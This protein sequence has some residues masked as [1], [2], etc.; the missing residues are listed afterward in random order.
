MFYSDAPLCQLHFAA[1]LE[2][3]GHFGDVARR[4]W[5]GAGAEWHEFGKR[6]IAETEGRSIHLND[7]EEHEAKE[8]EFAKQVENMAPPGTRAKIAAEKLAQL[9]AAEQKAWNTPAEKRTPKQ[10][11]LAALVAPRL[12]VACDEIALRVAG[13]K[14][15]EARQLAAKAAHHRQMAAEVNGYRSLVNFDY[16]RL[17]AQAEQTKEAIEARKT[18]WDGDQADAAADLVKARDFYEKGL[19]GWRKVL[20]RFPKLKED[21]AV[22]VDEL[23]EMIQRYRRILEKSD[24]PFP[25]PFILQDILDAAGKRPR[26]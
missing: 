23:Y 3:D 24:K 4:A 19:A 9:S 10:R 16:W 13:E 7:R 25:K 18:I 11:E 2:K 22:I 17:R 6:A 26:R 20:D 1:E 21:E 8:Q 14:R 12:E 15:R 5:Q